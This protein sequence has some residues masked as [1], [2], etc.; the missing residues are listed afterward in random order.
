M[1]ECLVGNRYYGGNGSKSEWN[2]I[3]YPQWRVAV[4]AARDV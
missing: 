3:G 2:M 4:D 1:Q